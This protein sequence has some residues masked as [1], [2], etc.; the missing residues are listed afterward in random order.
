MNMINTDYFK[1]LPI[2]LALVKTG[3]T[4]ENLV[5]E[6]RQ[7]ICLLYLAKGI[8]KKVCNNIMNSIKYKTEWMLYL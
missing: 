5:N 8:T 1:I 2:A 6:I 4:P 3:N 7:I